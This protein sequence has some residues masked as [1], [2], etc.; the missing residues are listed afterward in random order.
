VGYKNKMKT[1]LKREAAEELGLT[2]FK[3]QFL[4]KYVWE[5]E[6]ESELGFMFISRYQKT[7]TINK[8]EIDEEY[9]QEKYFL[10]SPFSIT[11]IGLLSITLLI[12]LLAILD[13]NFS[14][15]GKQLIRLYRK[16]SLPFM[17]IS[18]YILTLCVIIWLFVLPSFNIVLAGGTFVW[19]FYPVRLGITLFMAV[20]GAYMLFKIGQVKILK[21][22]F[23]IL[24]ITF[25]LERFF[26]YASSQNMMQFVAF[27]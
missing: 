26:T 13:F 11:N 22:S 10:N 6:V 14:A 18:T 1:L 9:L 25:G 16:L 15:I 19:Y 12:S 24:L 23:T 5:S 17:I 8:E 7:I 4:A 3:V 27:I 20:V 21:F 2:D